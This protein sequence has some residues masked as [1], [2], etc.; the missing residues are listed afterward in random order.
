MRSFSSILLISGLLLTSVAFAEDAPVN[1]TPRFKPLDCKI[2]V[3]NDV[4]DQLS[5]NYHEVY[6]WV[7]QGNPNVIVG[8][9]ESNDLVSPNIRSVY[10]VA[11]QYDDIRADDSK[12]VKSCIMAAGLTFDGAIDTLKEKNKDH[13]LH[14][15]PLAPNGTPVPRSPPTTTNKDSNGDL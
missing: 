14:S 7:T 9:F 15:L 5:S 6:E 8:V 13:T 3:S 12:V 4:A 2:P 11:T 10:E 1:P